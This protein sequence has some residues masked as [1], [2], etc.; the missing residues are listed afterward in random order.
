MGKYD[1]D[2]YD[3]KECKRIANNLET[4]L[5]TINTF[6]IINDKPKKEVKAAMKV[7]R[8]AIKDLREGRPDKVFNHEKYMEYEG[9]NDDIFGD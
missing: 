7:V 3:K 2:G 8:K 5:D 4:Y 9:M 6:V 1:Y